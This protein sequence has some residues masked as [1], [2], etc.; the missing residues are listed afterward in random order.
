V[1]RRDEVRPHR[2]PDN[3]DGE[4]LRAAEVAA[5]FEA[6]PRTIRLWADAGILPSFRTIGGQR[7]FR[8]ED[9]RRAASP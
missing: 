8:W 3:E 1:G 9:V 6:T 7:R 2:H 4:V 5:F